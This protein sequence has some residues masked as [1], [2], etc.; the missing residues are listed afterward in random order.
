[1]SDPAD[2]GDVE[3][4]T[5]AG[6]I[7]QSFRHLAR[8]RVDAGS[9]Y[10]LQFISLGLGFV[11]Q[12]IVARLAGVSGYGVYAYSFAWATIVVQPSLLGIDRAL[13]RELAGYRKAREFGLMRGL[14][15]RSNQIA[16][17]G[18]G[19]L[20]VVLAAIAI[21]ISSPGVRVSVAIGMLSIPLA[22]LSRVRLAALQGLRRATLGQLT[23]SV[24]RSAFFLVFLGIAVAITRST[25]MDPEIAVA[26]QAAAFGAALVAG[27]I[28]LRRVLPRQVMRS[29]P[30]FEGRKWARSLPTLALFS[31]F[32]IVSSQIPII[33]LG[34]IGT[35]A[36]TGRYNAAS[37]SVR[38]IE[39]ALSSVGQVIAPRVAILSASNDRAAIERLLTKSTYAAVGLALLP[40]A[41]LTLLGPWLLGLFGQGFSQGGTA[42][43]ILVV[44][45]LFNAATG[46]LGV[47]LLMTKHERPATVAVLAGTVLNVVLCPIL[48]PIWGA[49]GAAVA[50]SVDLILTNTLF[51]VVVVR[52]MKVRPAILGLR[53]PKFP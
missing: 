10:V 37:Q 11:S 23:Q 43:N 45:Q 40:A 7:R 19:S 29:T 51:V 18:A 3:A 22:T 20:T 1:M 33:M 36:A 9:T 16:L 48:I 39:I 30:Q 8:G 24:G 17:V 27:S 12:L 2:D 41:F 47:A 32:T 26:A 49:T 25:S 44:G 14:L 28:V 35:N 5:P 6:R 52:Y 4:V 34:I 53:L 42:L 38:L 13:I 46:S 31:L 21:P 15:R 50:S